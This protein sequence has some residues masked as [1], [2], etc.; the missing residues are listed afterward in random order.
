[1]EA[2]IARVIQN[3]SDDLAE[4]GQEMDSKSSEKTIAKKL[5]REKATGNRTGSEHL[6]GIEMFN[7]LVDLRV[8]RS[9][10]PDV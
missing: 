9:R 3:I 4:R 8:Y 1:V 10:Y 7:R 6:L 5:E 2:F